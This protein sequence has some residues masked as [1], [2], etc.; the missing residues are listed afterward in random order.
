[1][2]QCRPVLSWSPLVLEACHMTEVAKC[3]KNELRSILWPDQEYHLC[4]R[5]ACGQKVVGGSGWKA[6]WT[7][8]ERKV[9][10]PWARRF[11]HVVCTVKLWRDDT[12]RR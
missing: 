9:Q 10:P 11:C 2:H 5:H 8:G 1:V 12:G 7:A 3:T 6:T 4:R